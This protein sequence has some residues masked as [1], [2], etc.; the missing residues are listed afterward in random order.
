MGGG[1]S[2]EIERDRETDSRNTESRD[3]SRAT[4]RVDINATATF[5]LQRKV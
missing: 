5:G 3:R 4:H 1:R 2:R